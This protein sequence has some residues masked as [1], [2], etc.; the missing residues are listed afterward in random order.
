MEMVRLSGGEDLLS[1]SEKHI[2]FSFVERADRKEIESFAEYTMFN[3][4]PPTRAIVSNLTDA[5]RVRR[6]IKHRTDIKSR[7]CGRGFFNRHK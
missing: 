6:S 2:R 1:P 5:I 7:L 4:I 3:K